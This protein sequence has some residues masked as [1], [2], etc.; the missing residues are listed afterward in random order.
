MRAGVAE[1]NQI[2][3]KFDL[4]MKKNQVAIKEYRTQLDMVRDTLKRLGSDKPPKAEAAG[5]RQVR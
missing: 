2:K 3:A 5:L 1:E 4:E